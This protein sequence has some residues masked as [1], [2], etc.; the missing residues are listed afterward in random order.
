MRIDDNFAAS[1]DLRS[2]EVERAQPTA[3]LERQGGRGRSDAFGDSVSL[4]A[5][6][7]D[8]ARALEEESPEEVARVDKA[9]QAFLNG[10][11]EESP[12]AT[13][14]ALIGAAVEDTAIE[15]ALTAQSAT[16]S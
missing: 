15:Q 4:S 10:T 14:E 6:T 9:Q 2:L 13:A 7:A 11:L 1:S 16:A 8:I 5:L 3:P 12:E